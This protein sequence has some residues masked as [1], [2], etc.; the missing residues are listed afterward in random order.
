MDTV[1]PE[2]AKSFIDSNKSSTKTKVSSQAGK[3]P[4]TRKG[5]NPT[6]YRE[7]FDNIDWHRKEDK[8]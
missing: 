4:E 1:K 2:M 5:F 8:K 6:K 3:G 7:G